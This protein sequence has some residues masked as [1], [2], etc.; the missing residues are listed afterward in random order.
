MCVI[1]DSFFDCRFIQWSSFFHLTGQSCKCTVSMSSNSLRV[2]ASCVCGVFAAILWFW[3][4]LAKAF[5]YRIRANRLANMKWSYSH[6]FFVH[7]QLI[8][9]WNWQHLTE[10]DS[11]LT[12]HMHSNLL[13]L[14]PFKSTLNVWAYDLSFI[15]HGLATTEFQTHTLPNAPIPP[16]ISYTRESFASIATEIA[17]NG[18]CKRPGHLLNYQKRCSWCYG[19]DGVWP[20]LWLWCVI[21]FHIS[22]STWAIR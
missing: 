10:L 6:T 12:A 4:L 13:W 1:S 17:V 11:K 16:G 21:R 8:S 20:F 9:H 19:C 2:I 18:K 15:I 3:K 7:H 14:L 5:G 22:M